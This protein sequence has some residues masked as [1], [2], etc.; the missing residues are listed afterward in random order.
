[1]AY[2]PDDNGRGDLVFRKSVR[3]LEICLKKLPPGK[4]IS[5]FKVQ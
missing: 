5:I 1:M 3:N 4:I 2:C